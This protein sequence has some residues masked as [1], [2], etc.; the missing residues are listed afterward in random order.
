MRF[1]KDECSLLEKA[2]DYVKENVDYSKEDI[3]IFLDD[4][5]EHIMNNSSKN[6]E[7]NKSSE[8]YNDLLLK[9]SKL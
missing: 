8:E 2:G 7:I 3:Q 9:F 1:S 4:I 6:G 5:V